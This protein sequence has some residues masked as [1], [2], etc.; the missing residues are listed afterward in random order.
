MPRSCA[1]M[2]GKL[3]AID[4]NDNFRGWDDDMVVGSVHLVETFE[5][6]HTLRKNNWNGVWQLDQ[7]PFREDSV[8]AAKQAITFLKAIHRAL[9][10]LDEEASGR[11]AGPPRRLGRPAAGAEGAAHLDGRGAGAMSALTAEHATMPVLGRLSPYATR[12]EQIAHIAEA[13]RQIR[14]QDLKLVH[15]AGAG[16]IGGDFSAIDVLATLYGAV[17]NVTPETVED[18]ERDRFILSKGHVA[19]ALY[20][21]LAAFGFVPVEELATFL[22]PLSRL[23]GHPNR[24][25]VPGVEANTGPLGHG[26][27]IAVGHA[28]SAKLDVS[29]RRTYVL[30]GDGELQEGSNWEAMMAASQYEL[31]SLTVIVDRNRLQQGAT[32]R[33]TNDLDPLDAKAAAFGFAVV[34]VNGHDHGEL[35]DVLS[36]AP[37]RPGKPTFVIAHTHKGHPI[38]FMANNVAWH[39]KVPNAEP[40]RP[41]P[42]RA[43][44][45]RRPHD[46]RL[47]KT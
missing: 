47:R 37:F 22:K 14:I 20:T 26:L 24:N 6:F 33:E 4:V 29:R 8:Q 10:A 16:H 42:G 18:P 13:A 9:D 43:R 40:A 21:T 35:L 45:R 28:I 30:V 39:H 38:S 27:P 34:E 46:Q 44:L 19:G 3:F 25:K 32:T 7:F 1:S 5:F 31:D 17:L 12:D 41:G 2:H 11:S 36:A 15:H 23:N